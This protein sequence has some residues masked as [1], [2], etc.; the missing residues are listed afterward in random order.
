[1]I[2]KTIL[3]QSATTEQGPWRGTAEVQKDVRDE[4]IA[5][6]CR[7]LVESFNSTIAAWLTHWNFPGAAVPIMVRDAS[8]PEDLDARAK[9]EETVG[10][11]AGLRPT[12]AHVESVY[13]GEWEAAPGPA[14]GMRPPPDADPGDDGGFRGLCQ[15]PV[16]RPPRT[17]FRGRDRARPAQLVRDEWEP[18][19]EPVI[20][21]IL[22]AAGGALARGDSL[23]AFRDNLPELFAAMDD[24]RLVET[25]HAWD[26]RRRFRAKPGSTMTPNPATASA[27][28][29]AL[30]PGP[31][32]LM[33]EGCVVLVIGRHSQGAAVIEDTRAG[34]SSS[35]PSI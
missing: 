23:E 28:A 26:S 11:M 24:S 21:P 12:Q 15:R 18:M 8:P 5:A 10:R 22:V 35:V 30:A 4:V 25:L 33:P 29:D 27:A 34:S 32:R 31:A 17:A 3:G 13:G 16:R 7:L 9:R 19:M 6:D 2:A 1:M 20:E 14:A